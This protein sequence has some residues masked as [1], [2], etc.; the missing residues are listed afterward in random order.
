MDNEFWQDPQS[1]FDTDNNVEPTPAPE[2]PK[3]PPRKLNIGNDK[4]RAELWALHKIKALVNHADEVTYVAPPPKKETNL[5]RDTEGNLSGVK[6]SVMAGRHATGRD[7]AELLQ[8]LRERVY[9]QYNVK[10]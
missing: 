7:Q 6:H 2:Q 4:D 8:A 5:L 10:E 1:V 3:A 9:N